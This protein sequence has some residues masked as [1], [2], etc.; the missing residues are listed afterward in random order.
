MKT[1]TRLLGLF[2]KLKKIMPSNISGNNPNKIISR[3]KY[4]KMK[5]KK[6]N[7]R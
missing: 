5:P 7:L 3:I 1:K 4:N 2:K 6:K